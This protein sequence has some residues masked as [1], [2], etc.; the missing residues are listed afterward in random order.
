MTP[1]ESLAVA[2][3]AHPAAERVRY[4]AAE[5]VRDLAATAD[6]ADNRTEQ[7]E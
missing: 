4:L 3:R 5:R 6:M 2:L 1:A 7:G